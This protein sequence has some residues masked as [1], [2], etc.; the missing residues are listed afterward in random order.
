MAGQLDGDNLR[1][2]ILN[3]PWVRAVIPIRPGMEQQAINWLSKAHVEDS[4]GLDDTDNLYRATIDDPKELHSTPD[5][6]VTIRVALN[7]LIK[8]IQEFNR[9]SREPILPNPADPDDSRNHFAEHGF[10]SSL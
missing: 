2:A 6:K 7:Y 9:K 1:N 4:D 8:K 10:G 3:A 5:K